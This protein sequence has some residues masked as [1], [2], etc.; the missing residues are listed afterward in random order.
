MVLIVAFRYGY[1]PEDTTLNPERRSMVELE[2]EA[3]QRFGK[4]VLAFLQDENA[5]VALSRVDAV[6]GEGEKGSLVATFRERLMK[7][8]LVQT[9]GSIPELVSS[10]DAALAEVRRPARGSGAAA[11]GRVLL[12]VGHS[13]DLPGR[14]AP[15]FPPTVERAAARAI[16]EAVARELESGGVVF[17]MASASHGGDIL[18]L[19][20]CAYLELPTRIFLPIPDR[21]FVEAFVA[22]AG[23]D[24]VARYQRLARSSPVAVLPED[25]AV[26]ISSAHTQL[27][28]RW[29]R[30]ADAMLEVALA[31]GADRVT[32][33]ALWDGQP[34]ESPGGPTYLLSR[35]N[36]LGIRQVTID[37]RRLLEAAAAD[38]VAVELP[39]HEGAAEP[40]GAA[41]G[42]A[43]VSRAPAVVV[44]SS[45]VVFTADVAPQLR[46]DLVRT[47]LLAQLS[48]GFESARSGAVAGWQNRYFD[49]L[50][51]L[52][53]SMND[54]QFSRFEP[55]DG[56]LEVALAIRELGAALLGPRGPLSVLDA[57]VSALRSN[58]PDGDALGVFERESLRS[59]PVRWQIG[60][61][62]QSADGTL[63]LALMAFELTSRRPPSALLS[64][65][66]PAADASLQYSAATLPIAASVLES[67]RDP[68]A[69]K[70]KD[71]EDR[72]V[73]VVP[74]SA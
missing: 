56:R 67:L 43:A 32:L 18:F 69:A 11:P 19:E 71:R 68:L 64:F 54:R 73:R 52:G 48:A 60:A 34:T 13:L 7:E 16:R 29:Q 58:G 49:V 66:S 70:L 17:G 74:F 47:L 59:T 44:G 30:N 33:I 28:D 38:P 8:R 3:A 40:P 42:L 37:S 1:V 14:A 57:A 24:W 46:K 65:A 63:R 55:R 36:T 27:R 41:E 26:D 12:F 2:Y 5:A 9:F 53:W 35:A 62:E 39:P 20:A 21:K 25:G 50:S 22:P 61:V 10:V 15:R 45:L 23:P 6:S 4:P 31:Q 72:Y 51:N